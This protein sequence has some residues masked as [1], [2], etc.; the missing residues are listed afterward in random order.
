MTV[1]DKQHELNVHPSL[2]ILG[3]LTYELEGKEGKYAFKR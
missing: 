1:D 3:G 2:E